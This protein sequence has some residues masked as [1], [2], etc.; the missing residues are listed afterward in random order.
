MGATTLFE[1]HYS[2]T[3]ETSSQFWINWS[4]NDFREKTS[5]FIYR[6]LNYWILTLNR[7]YQI[8][9]SYSN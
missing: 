5:R 7:N 6:K 8:T 2:F 1:Q 4:I 9:L 3:F